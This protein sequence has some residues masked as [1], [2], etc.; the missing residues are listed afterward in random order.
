MLGSTFFNQSV[1][2]EK[3]Q[4]KIQEEDIKEH[5]LMLYNVFREELVIL[6]ERICFLYLENI[7]NL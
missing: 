4:R 6:I 2:E 1:L 7:G 3:V 5:L